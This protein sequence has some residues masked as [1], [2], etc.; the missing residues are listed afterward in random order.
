MRETRFFGRPQRVLWGAMHAGA[1]PGHGR[2]LIC[3]PLLQEGIRS[4]RALW[5]LAEGVAAA[6]IDALRFDW[7]GSG[8]SDGTSEAISFDGLHEDLRMAHAAFPLLSRATGR[9]RSMALRCAALPLLS[10]TV[11]QG[12]PADLLLWDPV[13][14]GKGLLARW[15]RQHRQQLHWAG[16]YLSSEVSSDAD[17]LV[18]F[19]L[20][21]SLTGPL[22]LFDARVAPLPAGSRLLLAVWKTTDELEAFAA[23]QRQ[24]GVQVEILILDAHDAPPWEDPEQFEAQAFPRRSVNQLVK[25][26]AAEEWR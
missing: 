20:G 23:L 5:T 11:R 22:A 12:Q 17:E 9:Q 26:L 2:L 8:D 7:Y 13:L 4:R 24:A 6:G 19:S 3:A 18:G 15:R 16:R 14:D 21:V 1:H 10:E 25:R